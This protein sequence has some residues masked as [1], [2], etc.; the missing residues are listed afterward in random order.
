[1]KPV[2]AA[3]DF[4]KTI[5]TKDMLFSFLC[6]LHSC[7][8][9]TL[10]SF[11]LLPTLLAYKL[12]VL[13]NHT[14]KQRLLNKFITDFS[15]TDLEYIAANFAKT[16]IPRYLNPRAIERIRWHQAQ[17]HRCILISAGLEIYLRPWAIGIG[18]DEIIATQL[19]ASQNMTQGNIKG[20]NCFGQ[21][22]V[23]RLLAVTGPK[24]NFILYAYGDSRGDRELLAMADY[25]FYKQIPH[26]I[27]I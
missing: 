15:Y 2:I 18:F 12:G 11:K 27:Q 10:K 19:E 23:N 16:K 1:M 22:K 20:R 25:G 13:D 9:N 14:A 24:E 5:T 7:P 17:K 26:E 3:F 6:E 4:D 21:E 8:Q